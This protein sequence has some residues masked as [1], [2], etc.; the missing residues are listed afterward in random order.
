M[1]TSSTPFSRCSRTFRAAAARSDGVHRVQ[2]P[3]QNAAERQQ[4]VTP[5]EAARERLANEAATAAKIEQPLESCA[6]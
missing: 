5:F 3:P 6:S 4:K 1:S 2:Q